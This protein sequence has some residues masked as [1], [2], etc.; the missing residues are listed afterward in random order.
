VKFETALAN[1]SNQV[2]EVPLSSEG[3]WALSLVLPMFRAP[4][5]AAPLMLHLPHPDR[6]GHAGRRRKVDV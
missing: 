5:H 3:I 6:L 1:R 2:S 4:G